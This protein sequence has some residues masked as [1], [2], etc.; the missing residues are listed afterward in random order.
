MDHG[1]STF[2]RFITDKNY[3]LLLLG[4]RVLCDEVIVKKPY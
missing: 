3:R 4:L 2:M 1:I